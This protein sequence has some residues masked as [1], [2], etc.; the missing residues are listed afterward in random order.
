MHALSDAAVYLQSCP[1]NTAMWAEAS[2]RMVPAAGGWD[3]CV[4]QEGPGHAD[5]RAA[6]QGE[7][8][9]LWEQECRFRRTDVDV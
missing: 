8:C 6:P 2:P 5:P 9:F 1:W 3:T 7:A 4:G